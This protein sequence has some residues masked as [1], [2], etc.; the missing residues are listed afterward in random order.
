MISNCE[1]DVHSLSKHWAQTVWVAPHFFTT[2]SPG[3]HSL[4]HS[5]LLV[6][7]P[8]SQG[9]CTALSVFDASTTAT[10]DE[11]R[12]VQQVRAAHVLHTHTLAESRHERLD[13]ASGYVVTL[14]ETAK[15]IDE[16][17]CHV[18]SMVL[19]C[20]PPPPTTRNHHKSACLHLQPIRVTLNKP[21]K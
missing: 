8:E 2:P 4:Q 7:W 17:H 11:R 13:A 10:Q 20:S 12:M 14:T 5:P 21:V 1:N 19:Y 16:N 9:S 18:S 6:Y 3:G 15:L